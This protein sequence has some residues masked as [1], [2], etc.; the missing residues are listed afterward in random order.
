MGEVVALAEHRL[1]RERREGVREAIAEVQAGSVTTL[2]VPREG[3]SRRIG[4]F[5]GDGDE[6]DA[7]TSEKSI[8]VP[9]ADGTVP[10]LN[11]DRRFDEGRGREQT[12]CRGL[13]GIDKTLLLGFGAQ[14]CD[15]R[16]AVDD[17]YRGRPFSS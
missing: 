7:R 14:D 2:A 8:E 17:H 6:L 9:Y 11:H 1:V 13:E 5:R 3:V 16:G 12:H 15:E 4:V 10:R